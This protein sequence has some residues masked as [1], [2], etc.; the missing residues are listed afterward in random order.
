MIPV[1]RHSMY[2]SKKISWKQRFKI[3]CNVEQNHEDPNRVFQLIPYH[4]RGVLL[5]N[6][7]EQI[8]VK[9][10]KSRGVAELANAYVVHPRY[11]IRV[12]IR[13]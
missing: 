10:S 11:N 5:L 2:V 9:L 7:P 8:Q 4:L 6:E 3:T 12:Q 13:H 1:L